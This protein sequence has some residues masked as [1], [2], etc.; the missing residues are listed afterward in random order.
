MHD[1]DFEKQVHQKMEELRLE[2][3]GSVWEKVETRLHEKEKRRPWMIWLPLLLVFI[4][5]GG[6][7]FTRHLSGYPPEVKISQSVSD[8]KA[9]KQSPV[10]TKE[11]VLTTQAPTAGLPR[12]VNPVPATTPLKRK[13]AA[14]FSPFKNRIVAGSTLPGFTDI[15]QGNN[16]DTTTSRTLDEAVPA[17]AEIPSSINTSLIIPGEPRFTKQEEKKQVNRWEWGLHMQAGRFGL[18][19]G[20]LTSFFASADA[21]SSNNNFSGAGNTAYRPPSPVKAAMGFSTGIIARR[22]ISDRFTLS[23]GLNYSQFTTSHVVGE[24]FD[25]SFWSGLNPSFVPQSESTYYRLGDSRKYLNRYHFIELPVLLE[26]KLFRRSKLPV[27]WNA[28]FAVSRLITGTQLS[29]DYSTGLYSEDD[30]HVNK[31]QFSVITGLSTRFFDRR[32][33]PLEVGPQVQYGLSN[34]LHYDTDGSK[35][36]VFFSLQANFILGRK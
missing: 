2:P 30:A 12:Q 35:H 15:Q 6:Y 8:S 20:K 22:I 17:L 10:S 34:F 21:L 36:L 11:P 32:R 5:T 25:T 14:L 19:S 23:A 3:S 31:T 7:F 13:T 28:G 4:G 26:T 24:K 9:E 1:H 18:N 16:P 33:F 27:S 29:Y